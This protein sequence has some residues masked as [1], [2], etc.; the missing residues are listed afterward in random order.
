MWPDKSAK[1]VPK[2]LKR[3]GPTHT[4]TMEAATKPLTFTLQLDGLQLSD[5]DRQDISE[6]LNDTLMRKLG[7]LKQHTAGAAHQAEAAAK[8][9]FVSQVIRI[10]GG[11]IARLLRKQDFAGKIGQGQLDNVIGARLGQLQQ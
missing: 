5:D 6:A 10:D 7:G 1:E 2:I 9:P 4:N 3:V 8:G 11:E